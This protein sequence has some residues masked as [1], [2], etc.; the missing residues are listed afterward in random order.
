MDTKARRGLGYEGVPRG[1][2]SNTDLH[3]RWR[4]R[5]QRGAP[6]ASGYPGVLQVRRGERRSDNEGIH[7]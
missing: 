3:S 1:T 6:P 2:S 7:L 4:P 5:R